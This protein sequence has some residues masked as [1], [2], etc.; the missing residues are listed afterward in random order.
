MTLQEPGEEAPAAAGD[1]Q[2]AVICCLCKSATPINLGGLGGRGGEVLGRWAAGRARG[3]RELGG[4]TAQGDVGEGSCSSRPPAAP[5]LHRGCPVASRGC[6]VVPR[7]LSPASFRPLFGRS[8]LWTPRELPGARPQELSKIAWRALSF[9]RSGIP[10][11]CFNRGH[12]PLSLSAQAVSHPLAITRPLP[13]L[14]SPWGAP[15][16]EQHAGVQAAPLPPPLSQ[17]EKKKPEE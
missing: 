11:S 16:A 4:G 6:G 17:E 8:S 1:F 13:S 15:T 3:G 7:P 5:C 14:S 9:R 10:T 12:F 2:N